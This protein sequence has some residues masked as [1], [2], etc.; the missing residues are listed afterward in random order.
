MNERNQNER[1]RTLAE[2]L[3]MLEPMDRP[4]QLTPREGSQLSLALVEFMTDGVEPDMLK[5]ASRFMCPEDYG[6]IVLER[7][8][9]HLCGYPLCN[10]DPK[11]I[12]KEHQIN[13]RTPTM[14]L[15]GTYLS[16]F[17]SRE[18]YQASTFYQGQLSVQPL[19]ARKDIT[20]RPFGTMEY[21]TQVALLEE[22]QAISENEH[23]SMRQVIEEFKKLNVHEDEETQQQHVENLLS[24]LTEDMDNVHLVERQPQHPPD[25]QIDGTENSVEGYDSIHRI[26]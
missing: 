5:F 6:E 12:R 9:L 18:H 26:R 3:K 13:Y 16:K 2:F 17:C 8:I 19:F 1:R 4:G 11:G 23:K 24:G 20:H 10:N 7:N 22:V 14:I 21:E 25:M 15:P